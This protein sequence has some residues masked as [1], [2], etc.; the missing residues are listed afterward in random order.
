MRFLPL[1]LANLGRRKVRTAL[2][3]GSFAVA[4]FLFGLLAAIRA[5]FRAGIDVAGAD[6]LVVLNRV[7]LIQ[8]LPMAYLERLRRVPG[9]ADVTYA[10]WFGGV[11]QDE[12]NFFPQFAVEAESYRRMY[13]EFVVDEGAWRDFIADR[14]GAI[15]GATT[16][17]RF[18][19]KVGDRIPLR[20]TIYPG[21]WELNL[22]A[23]YRGQRPNDDQTQLWLHQRYLYEKGPE[24]SRGIVGWYV[25]RVGDPGRAVEV[26]RAIDEGFAN[27]PWESRTQTERAFAAAF[28]QQVGNIE[29]L[30]LA[31]G[32][33]VFFTLLLVTGNTMAIAVRERTGEMAV[34]KAL[35]YSDG[36]CLGLVLVESVVVA[37]VGGALGLAVAGEV[38][39]ADLTQG[40]LL[41]YLS[42]EAIAAGALF[43]LVTGLLA[44]ALPAASAMRLQVVEAL[45]RV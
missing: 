34:L 5:G 31:I 6:R 45:R 2:T 33:V 32:A 22:R 42:P 9:V 8:P 44:G 12:R 13:P 25:V 14:S 30:I 11:Y 35:G 28:V 18:G 38:A 17:A 3:T 41:L 19:W 26:A 39:G 1:L 24:W 16:A 20:G 37:L 10:S 29:F 27:S 21:L 7:S 36:F 15:V 43:A 4:L 23:I 40:I